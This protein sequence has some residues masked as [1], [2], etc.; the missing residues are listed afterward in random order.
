VG[1]GAKYG[2]PSNL[3]AENTDVLRD[4]PIDLL[5]Q[6]KIDPGLLASFIEETNLVLLI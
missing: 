1:G 4:R 3:A 6:L 5:M 2:Q